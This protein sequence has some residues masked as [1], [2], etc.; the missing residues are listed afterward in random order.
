MDVVDRRCSG[1][2][3]SLSLSHCTSVVLALSDSLWSLLVQC[4][5]VCVCVC[6]GGGHTLIDAIRNRVDV[7]LSADCT[8]THCSQYVFLVSLTVC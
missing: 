7:F 4:V 6:G 5:C 8:L 2:Q 1:V 3:F